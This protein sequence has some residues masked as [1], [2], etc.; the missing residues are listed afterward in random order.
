MILS[1]D[2][3]QCWCPQ[4]LKWP[5]QDHPYQQLLKTPIV[6]LFKGLPSSFVPIFIFICLNKIQ[7]DFTDVKESFLKRIF[8]FELIFSTFSAI[9]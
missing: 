8:K 2:M 3:I 6:R 9:H 7:H 5:L 1:H 4:D